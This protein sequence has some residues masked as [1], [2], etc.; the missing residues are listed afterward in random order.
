MGFF[1]DGMGTMNSQLLFARYQDLQRYVGWERADEERVRAVASSLRPSF[2]HIIDDFYEE[3]ERHPEARRVIT[4][5][6]DQIERLKR[7]LLSWVEE[8]FFGDYDADYVARRWNVGLRHVQ[9][10]LNQVYVNVA[11]S[12]MRSG[13]LAYHEQTAHGATED[14]M[15]IR[16]SINK[17]I[18]LDLAIIE[19]AYQTEFLERQRRIERLATIGQVAGG[20]AHELRNPLNVIKTSIYYLRNARNAA[21]DKVATHLER[22]DRQATLA[23]GVITALHDFGRLPLPQFE[24]VPLESLL[25][26]IVKD[27]MIRHNIQVAIECPAD[28][29]AVCADPKQL[30]IVLAN[31]IRNAQEAMAEGGKLSIVA[32]AADG[33]VV[34]DVADTGVGMSGESL[35][36]FTEPFHST[37]TRGLGLGL[38]LVRAILDRHHGRIAVRSQ[39]GVGTTVTVTIPWYIQPPGDPSSHENDRTHIDRR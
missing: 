6:R 32:G 16:R 7:S 9:V 2:P 14:A 13:L 31:L 10:G 21:P 12:R 27:S 11:M 15:L 37:K 29:P 1:Y 8:L 22:I 20:I 18:D 39:L 19:D 17:L 34:I 25:K 4:G 5:G 23:D 26:D 36:R 35:A 3:I 28:L 24:A 33:Q 30:R 38:A